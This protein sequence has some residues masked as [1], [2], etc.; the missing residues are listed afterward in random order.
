MS[1]EWEQ[2]F[3]LSTVVAITREISDHTP[4][5]INTGHNHSCSNH[6]MFKFELGWLL[7]DVFADMVKNIWSN[8]VV[9]GTAMERWQAKIR[10]L[11]QHLRSWAKNVSGAY[12]KEKKKLLDTL[13]SLDKKAETT[14][15]TLSEIDLK[16]C[17]NNRLT[18]L[19]HDEEV[20]W[21]Q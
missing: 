3:S 4:L 16:C 12:K 18:Q 20:K 2:K 13:D 11:R 9:S 10:R 5:I 15:L 8:E 7:R 17:L 6:I 19:L 1:T 14:L 21:Y